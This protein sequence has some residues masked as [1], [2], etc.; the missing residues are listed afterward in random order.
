MHKFHPGGDPNW[1][2]WRY[3]PKG[4]A[5]LC[6]G[7]QDVPEGFKKHPSEHGAKPLD[8]PPKD[9]NEPP[10]PPPPDRKE[11]MA[12]LDALGVE[13]KPRSAVSVLVKLLE[14]A[15]AKAPEEPEESEGGFGDGSEYVE[16]PEE[17]EGEE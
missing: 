2:S 11:V 5:V 17:G 10:A 12:K 4:E 3:G 16:E 1:P 15:E 9:P 13:Y 8:A 14:D 6:Q 7:P